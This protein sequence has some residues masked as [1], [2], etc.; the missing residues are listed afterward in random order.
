[1]VQMISA[2]IAL[3]IAL[4]FLFSTVPTGQ[5]KQADVWAPLRFFVGNWEGTAEGQP[6]HSK[7]EREYRLVLSNKFIQTQNR[8]VYEPQPKNP[9]GEVHEDWGMIS[10]DK[11]RKQFVFRQFHIE[12]FVNEYVSTSISADGTTI[13]F[14]SESIENIPAGWRARETYRIVGLDE[15]TETFELA[16][17]GKDLQTYS[18]GRFRRKK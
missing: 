12:G 1:M 10:F 3:L 4:I 17:P 5:S 13:V 11:S 14:T 18:E 15:F 7:V 2:R 9:K 8:S 6:G 16:E